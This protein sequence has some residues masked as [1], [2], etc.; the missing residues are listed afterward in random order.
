[1]GSG[2]NNTEKFHVPLAQLPLMLTSYITIVKTGKLTSVP[3]DELN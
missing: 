1:M 3:N 2:Q